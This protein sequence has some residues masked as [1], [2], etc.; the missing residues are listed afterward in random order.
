MRWKLLIVVVLVATFAGFG[1]WLALT[2]GIFG[3]AAS[4]SRQPLWFLLSLIIPLFFVVFAAFFVYRH[5]ARRRKLQALLTAI[6]VAV[7][8]LAGYS[9]GDIFLHDRLDIPRQ[10]PD[11]SG[12]RAV[13]IPKFAPLI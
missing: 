10:N 12:E 4:M 3:S 11:P 5:T 7:G 1:G 9:I 13:G 6:L 8:I 2:V